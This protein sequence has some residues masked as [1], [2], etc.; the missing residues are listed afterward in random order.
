MALRL[1]ARLYLFASRLY[2][3]IGRRFTAIGLGVVLLMA[4]TSATASPDQAM[5]IPV[6]L[7]LCTLVGMAMLP[8]LW[9]RVRCSIQREAPRLV[10]AGEPFT[11]RVRLR[12]DGTTLRRDLE[13]REVLHEAPLALHEVFRRLR[14]AAEGPSTRQARC[15]AVELPALPARGEVV[16]EV[17]VT[18]WR[19]GPLTLAGGQVQ[20][21]DPLGIYRAFCISP[22]AHTVLVMPRRYPLPP[23]DLPG[24]ARHQQGGTALATGI[25]QVEEFVALRDYRRGD[26]LKQV[27]WRSAA[28]T[29][30]L[31]VKEY[32][33]EHQ[34][35]H[36]LILDTGCAPGDDQRFEEAVAIAASF[37]CTVPD[38]ES[39]LDLLLVADGAQCVTSGRGV[40]EVQGMLEVLATVQPSRVPRTAE[41]DALV[42]RH[43]ASLSSAVVVLLAW[44]APRRA[45]VRQ[46]KEQRLPTTVLLIQPRGAAAR[47]P[48]LPEEQPDRLITLT[49]GEIS[50]GLQALGRGA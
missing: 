22:A 35:R 21:T 10:T 40:G 27:H 13:Y 36:G 42:R 38:Q 30:K 12:H 32:Q 8:A 46:L 37:A 39:L 19:R 43:R 2:R 3:W 20:R 9:F 14:P 18:A 15:R 24:L 5:G 1:L 28:R 48:G 45:L 34:M 16:C 25:G 33:D 26:P 7:L 31:V 41:L 49:S 23:L 47:E 4:A 11:V 17:E 50:A 29:G 44:D 6:F